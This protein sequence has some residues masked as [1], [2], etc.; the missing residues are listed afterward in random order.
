M[1][2][3]VFDDDVTAST[4]MNRN[5][6]TLATDVGRSK[7]QMVAHNCGGTGLRLVAIPRRFAGK[8]CEGGFRHRVMVGVDDIPSRWEV[9][10]AR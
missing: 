8:D 4:N 3:R 6:M 1:R 7:V 9:L 5:M 10:V 2:G